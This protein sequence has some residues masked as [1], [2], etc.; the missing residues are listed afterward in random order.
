MHAAADGETDAFIEFAARRR[1][2]VARLP[3]EAAPPAFAEGARRLRLESS[4]SF[5]LELRWLGELP[6]APVTHPRAE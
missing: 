4:K 6:A 5:L 2:D 1:F 3:P